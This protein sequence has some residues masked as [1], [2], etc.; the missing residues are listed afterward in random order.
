MAEERRR[1]I[2]PFHNDHQQKA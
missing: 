1:G 2:D